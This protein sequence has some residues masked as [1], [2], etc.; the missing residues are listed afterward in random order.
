MKTTLEIPDGLYEQVKQ[1]AD[2]H[3]LTLP[4]VFETGLRKA[5]AEPPSQPF[6]LK[7]TSVGSGGMV[8]DF[9]W[10]ELR[11]IIYEDHGGQ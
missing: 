1:F 3:G 5:I 4:E 11:A 7:D 8:K 9:S 2:T 10:P 6:R